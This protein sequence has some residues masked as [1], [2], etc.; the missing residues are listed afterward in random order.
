MILLAITGEDVLLAYGPLG[1]MAVIALL[2][3]KRLIKDNDDLRAE[4]KEM[5][6]A[7][8]SEVVPLMKRSTDIH[9]KR[10]AADEITGNLLRDIQSTQR[11]ILRDLERRR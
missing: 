9:E 5:T 8:L 6:R 10:Q 4:N 2:L 3:G 1:V 7:M 11:E